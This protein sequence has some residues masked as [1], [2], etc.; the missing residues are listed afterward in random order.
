[1]YSPVSQS[2]PESSEAGWAY[3]RYL[4]YDGEHFSLRYSGPAPGGGTVVVTFP[5]L[6]HDTE[7]DA[8]GWGEGFLRK[9]GQPMV[10]VGIRQPNWYQDESFFEAMLAL[11]SFIGPETELICYGS[12]MGAYGAIL[13]ANALVAT[14]VVAFCPQYSIDQSAAP[15]ERRFRTE[16]QRIGPFRWE[17]PDEFSSAVQYLVIFDP[18]HRLDSMQRRLFP[19]APNW[20]DLPV[21]GSGHGPL[22]ALLEM[23]LSNE[24][25]D[26]IVGRISIKD[27]RNIIRLSRLR[28]AGYVRRMGNKLAERQRPSAQIFIGLAAESGH[29]RLVRKWSSMLRG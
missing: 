24:L 11:R 5:D 13:S 23:G 20:R 22:S 8:L 29:K 10:C 25:F 3:D 21:P 6:I 7:K 15:F 19:S 4:F 2:K 28:S 12:S 18:T 1:M 17:T 26:V 16:S 14:R 9:R 27:M